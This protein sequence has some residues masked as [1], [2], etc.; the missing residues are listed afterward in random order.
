[1]NLAIGG[2]DGQIAHGDTFH[3][4]GFFDCIERA[5]PFRV[6]ASCRN[7]LGAA[8]EPWRGIAL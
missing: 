6:R 3:G 5:I 2:I 8:S 7:R 1:M 4:D